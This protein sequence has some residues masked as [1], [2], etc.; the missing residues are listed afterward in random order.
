MKS[1]VDLRD[2]AAARFAKF[3]TSGGDALGY[4]V[5]PTI[6]F[7]SLAGKVKDNNEYHSPTT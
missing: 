4:R 6:I 3:D 5:G 2:A 1:V 7:Q